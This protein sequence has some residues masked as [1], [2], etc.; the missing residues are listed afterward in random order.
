MRGFLAEFD[1]AC[2]RA[3][4]GVP[5]VRK[6]APVHIVSRLRESPLTISSGVP[7]P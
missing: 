7:S 5:S 2:V 1:N 4:I 6:L 3:G